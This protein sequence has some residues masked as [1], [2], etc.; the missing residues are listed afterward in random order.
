MHKTLLSIWPLFFGLSMI[1]IGSGLQN[2]LLG[3]RATAEGFPT[4]ATGIIMSMYFAGY[5]LGSNYVPKLIRRVGHIRVFSALAAIASTTIL[6]QGLFVNEVS[7]A[8]VRTFTGLSYAG[9]YIVI[10]S[11]LNNAV[12]NETRGK[13][14]ASYL[15]ILYSSMAVGQYLLNFS[16]PMLADLFILTAILISAA[17]VPISL[18]SRPAPQFGEVRRVSPKELFKSSPLGVYGLFAIGITSS[19][20]FSIGPV[21][22][23]QAG[24]TMPQISTFM[25]AVIAGGVIMQFPVGSLSDRYDRRKVVIWVSAA[26][27]AASLLALFL[28]TV[29][30]YALFFAMALVGGAALTLYG[31]CSAHTNDHL[32]R[33]QIVGA[34][35]TI[36]LINGAGSI[37]GP[38][39]S[40]SLMNAIA[41]W[42]W[43]LCLASVYGSIAVFGVYRSFRRAPVPAEKKSHYVPQPSPSSAMTRQ[44]ASDADDHANA[45]KTV[46]N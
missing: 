3:V 2:T 28:S 9:L 25:A 5:M 17:M 33:E 18:S 38:I 34:S 12:T 6:L 8:V 40:A 11:W 7:W 37:L 16:D 24:F 19:T 42:V 29:S 26:A 45:L 13:M 21:Y 32:D 43:Y 23:A 27:S 15:V 22:A 30:I 36:I 41:P 14:M 31:L 20:L 10:E 39:I 35:A 1:M 46:A 4:Y 44:Q